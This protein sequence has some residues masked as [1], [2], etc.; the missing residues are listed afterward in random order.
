MAACECPLRAM[1]GRIH[2]RVLPFNESDLRA[3]RKATFT[4]A[5]FSLGKKQV[6]RCEQ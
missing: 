2:P 1:S 3:L 4:D 6:Y 5:F